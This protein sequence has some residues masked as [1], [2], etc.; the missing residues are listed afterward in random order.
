MKALM[1]EN[2]NTGAVIF[3]DRLEWARMAAV[4]SAQRVGGKVVQ[5][6]A[7]ISNT[8]LCP[9]L[10]P[11]ELLFMHVSVAK[12]RGIPKGAI[13]GAALTPELLLGQSVWT[14]VQVHLYLSPNCRLVPGGDESKPWTE[15]LASDN[16][17]QDHFALH[18]GSEIKYFIQST[19]A[20][21]ERTEEIGTLY[22]KV[23][24]ENALETHPGMGHDLFSVIQGAPMID[25]VPITAASH[26]DSVSRLRARCSP[27]KT[28]TTTTTSTATRGGS[29]Q[30]T[31]ETGFEGGRKGEGED[32]DGPR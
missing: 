10:I 22:N 24:S 25:V 27:F 23:I 20:C 17:V 6:G 19:V 3:L 31:A 4:P 30:F 21:A 2:P 26:T 18:Y 9:A 12:G 32:A 8:E 13:K 29:N 15:G 14:A 28:V 11:K 1:M 7:N 16:Q 5:I